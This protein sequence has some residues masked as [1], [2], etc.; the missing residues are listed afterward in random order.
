M[1]HCDVDVVIGIVCSEHCTASSGWVHYLLCL[2]A[3]QSVL[4]L[5]LAVLLNLCLT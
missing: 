5:F 2:V 4:K 1:W 3:M